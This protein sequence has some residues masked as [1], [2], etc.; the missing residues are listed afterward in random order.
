M[1]KSPGSQAY[2]DLIKRKL[3]P[4]KT[5]FLETRLGRNEPKTSPSSVYGTRTRDVRNVIGEEEVEDDT[6]TAERVVSTD[7]SD[8]QLT[9]AEC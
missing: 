3:E 8:L 1:P 6:V 7:H 2:I 4:N 9:E 5:H